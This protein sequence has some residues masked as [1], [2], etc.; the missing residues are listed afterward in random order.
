MTPEVNAQSRFL[1]ISLDQLV[2]ICCDHKKFKDAFVNP[3]ADLCWLGALAVAHVLA[4]CLSP[5]SERLTTT[6]AAS[7][8]S[9]VINLGA[10]LS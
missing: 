10:L 2:V 1:G 4:V 6:F 7:S 3:R 9:F 8:P 5:A